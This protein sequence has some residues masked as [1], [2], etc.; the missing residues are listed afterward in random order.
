M[1]R[2]A[3]TVNA[4][5]ERARRRDAGT[6]DF[7]EGRAS[8]RDVR[9]QRRRV[10]GRVV[11]QSAESR[12]CCAR[13]DRLLLLLL[14]VAELTGSGQHERMLENVLEANALLG[15]ALEQA[16]YEVLGLVRDG[17]RRYRVLGADDA[18]Q[19][20]LG[21]AHARRVERRLAEQQVV[22]HAAERP[23]V[24]LEAV[25]RARR[26]LRR[27]EV[28]RAAHRVVLVVRARDD[29]RH[30]EV[31]DFL[32]KNKKHIKPNKI[33]SN[34]FTMATIPWREFF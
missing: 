22:H 34:L 26:H 24:G 16:V 11:G 14:S 20:L 30:A 1:Q 2:A 9:H 21:A 17:A 31:G 33:N 15:V 25:R 12:R 29:R 3:S 27:D 4:L 10:H 19:R 8:R 32:K 28:G 18:R 6:R 7:V 23:H 5:V 13:R